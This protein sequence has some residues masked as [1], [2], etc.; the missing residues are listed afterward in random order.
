LLQ[1]TQGPFCRELGVLR[2]EK[3]R[4]REYGNRTYSSTTNQ[5]PQSFVELCSRDA[6][7]MRMT[8]AGGGSCEEL[9]IITVVISSYVASCKLIAFS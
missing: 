7:R 1:W 3:G 9:I 2:K 8:Y 5:I 6:T 4:R